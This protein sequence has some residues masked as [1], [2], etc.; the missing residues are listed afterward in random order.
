MEIELPI[1]EKTKAHFRKYKTW[2]CC[3]G[4]GLLGAGIT[5]VIVRGRHAGVGNAASDG[6]AKVTV[7]PLSFLSKQNTNVVTVFERQGRGHPGYMV[8]CLET[9]VGY[10]SQGAAAEAAGVHK[11]VMSRHLNGMFPD[12]NGLHFERLEAA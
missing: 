3:A 8:R 10:P 9:N 12:A 2:Y 6:P 7:R 4:A 5:L 1:V 11:T